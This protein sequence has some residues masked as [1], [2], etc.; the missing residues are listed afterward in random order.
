MDP[1]GKTKERVEAARRVFQSS[2]EN[3][4]DVLV[5]QKTSSHKT[6]REKCLRAAGE[7]SRVLSKYIVRT[8]RPG[9]KLSAEA[10]HSGEGAWKDADLSSLLKI[11]HVSDRLGSHSDVVALWLSSS[12]FPSMHDS[13]K[14]A[15]ELQ[16]KY[17]ALKIRGL[18]A[19]THWKRERL[20]EEIRVRW[21]N[22]DKKVVPPLWIPPLKPGEDS[23]PGKLL[24]FSS[25][26][27]VPREVSFFLNDNAK[28]VWKLGEVRTSTPLGTFPP[29]E[30]GTESLGKR[31][32]G[33]RLFYPV[34]FFKEQEQRAFLAWL[35]KQFRGR[36]TDRDLLHAGSRDWATIFVSL[37]YAFAEFSQ[38]DIVVDAAK[39][40]DQLL[41]T[42]VYFDGWRDTF[43]GLSSRQIAQILREINYARPL[44]NHPGAQLMTAAASEMGEDAVLLQDSQQSI[45]NASKHITNYFNRDIAQR[46]IRAKCGWGM[47][48]EYASVIG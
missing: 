2:W 22:G 45:L 14:I 7:F 11:A 30:T 35:K 8:E 28:R 24:I 3:Y 9:S 18:N 25:W 20:I 10:I 43:D 6:A 46:I 5:G 42:Y 4:R 37:D 48:H 1:S 26:K 44:S 23:V 34:L 39:A 13:Y 33:W 27:A 17:S 31:K 16:Q 38:R 32:Q 15:E 19:E 47:N 29:G 12:H 21:G 36:K 41:E 40:R